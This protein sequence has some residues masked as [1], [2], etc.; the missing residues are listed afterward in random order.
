MRIN[1]LNIVDMRNRQGWSQEDLAAAAGISTRTVQR[2]ETEGKAS[3]D[4]AKAVAAAFDVTLEKVKEPELQW[5]HHRL[6]W[7]PLAEFFVSVMAITI[8]TAVLVRHGLISDPNGETYILMMMMFLTAMTMA[9]IGLRFYDEFG[10][11]WKNW[12]GWN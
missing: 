6:I 4:T 1:A 9:R 10:P 2:L 12:K 11:F 3:L 5:R 7:R 8:G